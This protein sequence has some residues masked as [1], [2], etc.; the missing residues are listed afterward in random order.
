MTKS[1]SGDEKLRHVG[2]FD[3]QL[4]ADCGAEP[5]V[6][7]SARG[8]NICAQRGSSPWR[9]IPAL[10]CLSLMSWKKEKGKRTGTVLLVCVGQYILLIRDSF[11]LELCVIAGTSGAWPGRGDFRLGISTPASAVELL[12]NLVKLTLVRFDKVVSL[13]MPITETRKLCASYI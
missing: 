9:L 2:S 6:H 12:I 5:R 11:W 3:D 10:G 4:V 7:A 8:G 13:E 1:V